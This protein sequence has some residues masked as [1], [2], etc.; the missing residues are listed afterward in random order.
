M[1]KTLKG[2]PPTSVT[3]DR[4]KEFAE[5]TQVAAEIG[6]RF[7]FAL[8]RRP[9]QRGINENANG[10]LREYLFKGE[11]LGRIGEKQG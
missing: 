10:F 5:Y 2:Q 1:P 7:F 8:P 9:W 3:L 11:S 4:G 6:A